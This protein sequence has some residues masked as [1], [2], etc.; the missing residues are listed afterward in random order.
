MPRAGIASVLLLAAALA[1]LPGRAQE[2]PV[3][4]G[5]GVRSRPAYDGSSARHTD[6]IPFVRYFGP[7]WFART[8]QGV[9]EGGVRENL[10]GQFSA[11]AQIAFEPGRRSSE[12]PLLQARNEPDLDPGVSAGLHLE[13]DRRFGRV[14]VDFLIRARQHLDFDR[15]G[16]ADLRINAGVFSGY[17]LRAVLFTQATWGS[18][19]AVRSLYATPSAALMYTSLGAAAAYDL[20]P[21]WVL[22][23]SAE[24]RRLRDEAE[25]SPLTEDDSVAYFAAWLA[26]RF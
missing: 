25:Q 22:L 13:W 9:L 7:R 4:L 10:G 20:H 2:G 1:A 3:L 16:Q 5:A 8:T 6:L 15:G 17:G 18:R 24:S 12:S 26:Y 21:R 11:G 19:N 14:P 23:A